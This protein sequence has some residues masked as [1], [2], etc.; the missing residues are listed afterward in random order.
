MLIARFY[1]PQRSAVYKFTDRESNHFSLEVHKSRSE[2]LESFWA[3]REAVRSKMIWLRAL[4]R[5]TDI[6]LSAPV[7]NVQGDLVTIVDGVAC[8][9]LTWVE[10]EVRKD[11]ASVEKVSAIGDMTGKLHRQSSNWAIPESFTRPVLDDARI[12]KAFVSLESA[13]LVGQASRGLRSGL[14]CF[15]PTPDITRCR[16]IMSS[17]WKDSISRRCSIR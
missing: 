3:S 11:F 15:V 9:L 16:E 8:S 14:S 2:N 5:E 4:S 13:S 6:T 12:M 7:M 17:C 10:G 1:W